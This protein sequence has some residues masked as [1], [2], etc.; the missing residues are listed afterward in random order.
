MKLV[1]VKAVFDLLFKGFCVL[2]AVLFAAFSML[3]CTA[4]EPPE[5]HAETVLEYFN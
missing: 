5:D 3:A 1:N 4:T 2:F